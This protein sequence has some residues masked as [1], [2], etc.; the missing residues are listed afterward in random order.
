MMNNNAVRV[1]GSTVRSFFKI[2]T[3]ESDDDNKEAGQPDMASTSERLSEGAYARVG[4]AAGNMRAHLRLAER[5][6]K[7]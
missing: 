7:G 2:V 3:C 1:A 4:E 5:P 6:Q